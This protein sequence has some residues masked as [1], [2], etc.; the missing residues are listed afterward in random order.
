MKN[1][2]D[3]FDDESGDELFQAYRPPKKLEDS[4]PQQI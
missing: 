3:E 1:F 4:T 2:L